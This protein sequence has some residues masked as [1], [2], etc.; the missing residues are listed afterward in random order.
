MSQ[1]AWKE[2]LKHIGETLKFDAGNAMN[3]M[4]MSNAVGQQ[5]RHY[6]K[7]VT[8]FKPKDVHNVR[9]KAEVAHALTLLNPES[10]TP[11]AT[12]ESAMVLSTVA[13]QSYLKQITHFDNTD[14]KN[15]L[16]DIARQVEQETPTRTEAHKPADSWTNPLNF[17]RKALH[18]G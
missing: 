6:I 4:E 11:M 17:I 3:D 16:N 1:E 2:K 7:I 18:R 12:E 8:A 13:Y 15:A 5:L 9:R 14:V 10:P